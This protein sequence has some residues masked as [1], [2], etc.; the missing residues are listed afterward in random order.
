MKESSVID[1]FVFIIVEED[2]FKLQSMT[3]KLKEKEILPIGISYGNL[4]QKVSEVVKDVHLKGK[5][6]IIFLGENGDYFSDTSDTRI[7]QELVNI[8]PKGGLLIPFCLDCDK[9]KY[10]WS[11]FLP[12]KDCSWVVPKE[13]NINIETECQEFLNNLHNDEQSVEF[14]CIN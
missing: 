11:Y 4:K 6:P 12:P 5:Y 13:P 7:V 9:Q 8:H 3:I 2:E 1:N 10:E 14:N